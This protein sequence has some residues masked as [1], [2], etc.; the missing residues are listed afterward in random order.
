[1]SHAPGCGRR[2]FRGLRQF[3]SDFAT[4]SYPSFLEI[5]LTKRYPT[6]LSLLAFTAILAA[7]G[8][9]AAKPEQAQIAAVSE[10]A[11]VQVSSPENNAT[12]SPTVTYSASATTSCA[13]GVGSMGIYTAPGKLAFTSDGD[14]L[15][16]DLSLQP[17]TYTTTVQA[18]DNCGD[19]ASKDVTIT[20]A[21]D[22]SAGSSGSGS[23]ATGPSAPANATTISDLQKHDGWTPYVL[24]PPGY[25]ICHE[26]KTSGPELTMSTKQGVSSPSLSG[27]SMQFTIGG[28]TPYSDGLWNNHLVGDYSSHG[29]PD[30]DQKISKEVH[31]FLYDVYFFGDHLELSQA[32]EFDINQFVDGK[33]FIWG[34][35]C[36][37]VG[38]NEWDVWDNA[39]MSWVPTGVACHPK[40]NEWNHLVLEVERTTDDQL[41]F[42]TITLNGETATLNTYDKPTSTSWNGI[43]INY[44]QDGNSAQKEYSI[45]LDKVNFSYW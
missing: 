4:P 26:C 43:T 1:M 11:T 22:D 38:G 15:K 19:S 33:S 41:L 10:S 44:Q 32:V 31:H 39:S 37:I 35:E 36:R 5:L 20:V 3:L 45:W 7:C 12:V 42:K 6:T 34:H 17:G 14:T 9:G 23:G 21:A 27:G 2:T 28:Q 40:N 30:P 24:L 25:G 18:W 13:K 8:G 16:T 29:K